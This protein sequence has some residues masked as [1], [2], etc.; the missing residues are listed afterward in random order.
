MIG[1]DRRVRCDGMMWGYNERLIYE[2]TM[3]G[4]GGRVCCYEMIRG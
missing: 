3:G 2:D 1:C 4:L